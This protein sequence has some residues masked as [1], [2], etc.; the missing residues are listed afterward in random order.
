MKFTVALAL[1]FAVA[2]G[3]TIAC[4]G[5]QARTDRGMPVYL[6]LE[7]LDGERVRVRELRGK[8]VV[9]HLFTVGSMAAQMDISQLNA[10]YDAGDVAV[11]GIALDPD[12][13]VLIRAWARESGAHYRVVIGNEDITMG[14]T[15]L[16]RIVAVPTT[17]L[18]NDKGLV[19]F[20][21]D[22]QLRPGEL[23]RALRS[24]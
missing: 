14:K 8:P 15:D 24:R 1:G 17:L 23:E 4:G 3:A 5:T 19:I 22:A 13:D 2:L 9:L 11:L 7:G 18:L 20:R 12:A 16:G 6:E 21:T 10:A